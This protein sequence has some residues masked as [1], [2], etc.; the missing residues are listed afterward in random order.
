M[1]AVLRCS[2]THTHAMPH[3]APAHCPAQAGMEEHKHVRMGGFSCAPRC[4][5]FLTFRDSPALLRQ[6]SDGYPV[7][8]VASYSIAD[9]P[10]PPP[11]SP[12][13]FF[14]PDKPPD[15]GPPPCTPLP[16]AA[17]RTH[18]GPTR[19]YKTNPASCSQ[20]KKKNGKEE[21]SGGDS[22]PMLFFRRARRSKHG[23]GLNDVYP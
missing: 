19:T 10:F 23:I 12:P 18:P 6:E 9:R 21:T 20:K 8:P 16:L 13:E 5:A 14:G 11:R 15:V 2:R 3:R 22:L 1:R 17:P 4:P 7:R